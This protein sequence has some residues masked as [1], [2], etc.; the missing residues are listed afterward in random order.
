MALALGAGVSAAS[1]A[2]G[3]SMLA[4][5]AIPPSQRA[6]AFALATWLKPAGCIRPRATRAGTMA[7]LRADNGC[8]PAGA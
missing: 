8:A 5:S 4:W 7:T 1:R 2:A 6:A 3:T